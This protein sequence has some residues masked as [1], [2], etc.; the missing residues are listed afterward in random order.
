MINV[1]GVVPRATAVNGHVAS[2]GDHRARV[3]GTPGTPAH[4]M[5]LN[6]FIRYNI[7]AVVVNLECVTAWSVL[8]CPR[9]AITLQAPRIATFAT[10]ADAHIHNKTDER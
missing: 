9:R 5:V 8:H 4:L 2:V 1:E 6:H 10:A 7:E 3:N